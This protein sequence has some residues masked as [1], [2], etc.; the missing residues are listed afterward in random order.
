MRFLIRTFSFAACL[1]TGIRFLQKM[2]PSP[3]H[4]S[5]RTKILPLKAWLLHKLIS[6]ISQSFLTDISIT[7]KSPFYRL[8]SK[9]KKDLKKSS[10]FYADLQGLGKKFFTSTVLHKQRWI[11]VPNIYVRV[12]LYL[13]VTNAW[14]LI[15]ILCTPNKS[16]LPPVYQVPKGYSSSS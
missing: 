11:S 14:G 16:T 5:A 15:S 10:I 2:P 12:R 9:I 7:K 4:A 8:F 3:S 1:L 6:K 13:S